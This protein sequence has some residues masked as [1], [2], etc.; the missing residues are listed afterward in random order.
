MLIDADV[1][2]DIA[3]ASLIDSETLTAFDID[4]DKDADIDKPFNLSFSI[5]S[6]TLA[7]KERASDIDT[8]LLIEADTL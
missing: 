1:L 2:S 6:L 3:T 7:D 8:A 4:S 5:C